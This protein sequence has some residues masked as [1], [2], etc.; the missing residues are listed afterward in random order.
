MRSSTVILRIQCGLR[1][2]PLHP[3]TRI[4]G[5]PPCAVYAPQLLQYRIPLYHCNLCPVGPV[6]NTLL[7]PH[8]MSLPGGTIQGL[9]IW[10]IPHLVGPEHLTLLGVDVVA[11]A[12]KHVFC[13]GCGYTQ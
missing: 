5:L 4:L 2:L 1:P 7:L 13:C 9:V 8:W 11:D 10:G 3:C 12:F 6:L